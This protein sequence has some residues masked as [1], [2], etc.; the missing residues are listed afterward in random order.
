M[1]NFKI[2]YVQDTKRP[3]LNVQLQNV[4]DPKRP[5]HKTYSFVNLKTCFKNVLFHY[6]IIFKKYKG[7]VF[8]VEKF[9]KVSVLFAL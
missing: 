2:Q 9:G 8:I 4:Q 6:D 7:S 1:F 3:L 5:G